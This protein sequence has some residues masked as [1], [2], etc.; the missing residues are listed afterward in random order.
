ML[1]NDDGSIDTQV[2]AIDIYLNRDNLDII[3]E[4]AC[5]GAGSVERCVLYEDV[6]DVFKVEDHIYS[7]IP[8]KYL[9]D[10]HQLYFEFFN[11][12]LIRMKKR[13]VAFLDDLFLREL[14]HNMNL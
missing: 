7:R 14:L 8:N 2:H 4:V 3:L 6:K 1:L 11:K 12:V 10:A 13:T 5:K 9:K